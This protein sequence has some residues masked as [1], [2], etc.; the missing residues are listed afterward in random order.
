MS[1]TKEFL[2]NLE[3][4]ADA[5]FLEL[6][7]DKMGAKEV[8]T[9]LA[10]EWNEADQQSELQKV[11]EL[12][13]G[14]KADK[15]K[16]ATFITT[17]GPI[18]DKDGDNVIVERLLSEFYNSKSSDVHPWFHGYVAN[19]DKLVSDTETHGA[20]LLRF[21]TDLGALTI[22]RLSGTKDKKL[23]GAKSRLSNVAGGWYCQEK[24]KV[25]K[26]IQDYIKA[27]GPAN[28]GGDERM[29]KVVPRGVLNDKGEKKA[30]GLNYYSADF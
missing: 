15:K 7:L 21:A 20:F 12:C 25:F 27:R 28:Q 16:F 17:F 19:A 24:K 2:K 26:T 14:E 4:E 10:S 11:L 8:A 23:R 18:N 13:L 22:N 6:K 3:K 30:Q 1:S 9:A 5:L 29:L